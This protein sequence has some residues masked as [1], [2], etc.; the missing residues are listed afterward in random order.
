MLFNASFV[1]LPVSYEVLFEILHKNY[2][3]YEFTLSL[4]EKKIEF[5]TQTLSTADN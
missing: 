1:N 3:I 4:D 2:T 5:M